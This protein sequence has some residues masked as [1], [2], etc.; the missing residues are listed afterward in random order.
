M[1]ICLL[2][3]LFGLSIAHIELI[4]QIYVY[5]PFTELHSASSTYVLDFYGM[6]LL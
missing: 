5:I 1:Y 4:L 2:Q 3:P 6:P